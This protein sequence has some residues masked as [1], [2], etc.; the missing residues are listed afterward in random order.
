MLSTCFRTDTQEKA[1]AI[2]NDIR[3]LLRNFG[4]KVGV[5]RAAKFEQRIRE[6]VEGLPDLSELMEVL[7]E[8]RR[9]LREQFT[10]L[11]RKLLT[12]VRDDNVCRPLDGNLKSAQKC[13]SNKFLLAP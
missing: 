2:D 1:I 8:A 9:E 12:I 11:H 3:G 7:L 5:V 4:L 6:L 10:K 13:F